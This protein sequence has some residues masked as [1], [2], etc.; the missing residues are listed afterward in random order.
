[1][2]KKN[3]HLYCCNCIWLNKWGGINCSHISNYKEKESPVFG[4]T[5]I[6]VEFP[7]VKN[8]DYNCK[9]YKEATF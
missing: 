9:Y 5:K 6:F 7:S 1:M 8:K 2:T 4:I 3:K